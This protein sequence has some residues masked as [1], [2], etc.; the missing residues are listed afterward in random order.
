MARCLSTSRGSVNA[1][2]GTAERK[3]CKC[4]F[5]KRKGQGSG[6]LSPG[7]FAFQSLKNGVS[8][9]AQ[10]DDKADKSQ[11]KENRDSSGKPE[12]PKKSSFQPQQQLPSK[13]IKRKDKETKDFRGI[14]R[15]VGKDVDGHLTV[16]ESLRKVKGVGYNL[17]TNLGGIVS[18]KLGIPLNELVGNLSE[19][20]FTKL[21]DVV[22][23]PHKYGVKPFLLNRQRDYDSGEDKHL[24]MSDLTFSLR[25]DI[26]RERDS[27]TYR[28]WRHSLGQRVRGQHNRTTGRSG[29]TVG[30]LK[31]AI[32][33]QKA[34]AATGA[35]EKSSTAPA[36]EEKKK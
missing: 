13:L 29:M 25:Q 34:A 27:R 14:V 12:A 5:R 32:K 26:V 15:V 10:Q 7:A 18:T 28:G 11:K 24:V 2:K 3:F 33:A 22:R 1:S 19:E 8:N 20:Q 36:K 9:L 35:Q 30:V 23:S 21:E 6:I 4:S 31:K 16:A 17:G